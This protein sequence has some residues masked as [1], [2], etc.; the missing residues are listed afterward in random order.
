MTRRAKRGEAF[1]ARQSTTFQQPREPI[2]STNSPLTRSTNLSLFFSLRSPISA[3][4][5]FYF[6]P[7]NSDNSVRKFS[8]GS[9]PVSHLKQPTNTPTYDFTLYFPSFLF[10]HPTAAPYAIFS[11]PPSLS[12]SLPLVSLFT[13]T[14]INSAIAVDERRGMAVKRPGKTKEK[15]YPRI[16]SILI[17]T[18]HSTAEPLDQL[19]TPDVKQDQSL[20]LFI[21]GRGFCLSFFFYLLLSLRCSFHARL[22]NTRELASFLSL[23]A[24]ATAFSRFRRRQTTMMVVFDNKKKRTLYHHPHP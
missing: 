16:S 23:A 1:S 4:I 20:P 2:H 9:Q 18:R 3:T 19:E 6:Q 10:Y 22:R 17:V 12:L 14:G 13:L 15:V 21:L 7:P 5:V 11:L 8:F 24:A